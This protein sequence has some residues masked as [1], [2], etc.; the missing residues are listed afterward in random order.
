M[1][2]PVADAFAHKAIAELLKLIPGLIE[3]VL[4]GRMFADQTLCHECKDGKLVR[5][6]G[7][8]W[9]PGRRDMLSQSVTALFYSLVVTSKDNGIGFEARLLDALL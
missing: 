6:G 1:V 9:F 8:A 4:L 3:E 5:N 2:L 7:T